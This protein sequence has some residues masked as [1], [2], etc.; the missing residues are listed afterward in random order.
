M[1]VG[2]G[3]EGEL[4]YPSHHNPINNP[5]GSGEFQCY[6]KNMLLNLKQHAEMHGN[7]LWGLGGPHDAPGYDQSPLSGGFFAENGGSWESSYGDFF[8]SW[9]SAQLANHADQMLSVFASTF[10]DMPMTLSGKVPLIHPWS[11]LRSRPAESTAGFYNTVNRDGYDTIAEIFSRNSC[12]MMLPEMDSPS[13]S[14]AESLLAQ[15]MSS[16][17]K[18]GTGILGCNSLASGEFEQIKNKLLLED[19]GVESFMYQRM[20]AYFFSPEHFPA[21]TRFVHGLNQPIHQSLDDL[22]VEGE[23]SVESLLGMNREMQMA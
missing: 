6:D 23:G 13:Q 14:S 8:L 2:L 11:N 16:C 5:P 10:K 12:R 22:P 19:A 7:P 3:P 4:R 17:R 21:F 1:S 9:Y 18:Q 15:V 20:G